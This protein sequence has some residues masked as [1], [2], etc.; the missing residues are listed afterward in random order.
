MAAPNTQRDERT[1]A[2][3]VG[4]GKCYR[5]EKGTVKKGGIKLSRN[6]RDVPDGVWA[7]RDLDNMDRFLKS[8]GADCVDSFNYEDLVGTDFANGKRDI[9]ER[10]EKHFEK[11]A[12]YFILYYT[13]HGD[14]DGSWVFPVIRK[15]QSPVED[16][17]SITRQGTRGEGHRGSAA[18]VLDQPIQVDVEVHVHI[19]NNSTEQ[20]SWSAE[21]IEESLVHASE[22]KDKLSEV[23]VEDYTEQPAAEGSG[24]GNTVKPKPSH[25]ETDI[26]HISTADSDREKANDR[27]DRTRGYSDF[28]ILTTE[29]KLP[30][31]TRKCD[32]IT[33][34]E[35]LD[36]WKEKKRDRGD[37]Y[38]MI[39]LD[40]CYAGKWVEK[41]DSDEHRDWRDICIQAVCRSIEI[42]KV[43]RDQ[44]SSVFTRDFVAAHRLSIPQKIALSVLDHAFVLNIAS[45][46]TSDTF[47]PVSS[48]YA[49]FGEIKKF[50]SYDDMYL[51][52]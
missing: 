27:T 1:C 19:E 6:K 47:S 16:P 28:E 11:E 18:A 24:E 21:R 25:V 14:H 50:D 39:I 40:C 10:I 42:C 35:I 34:E 29:E 17:D 38:L 26:E 51:T 4:S 3:L 44:Q 9:I 2:L 23:E 33:F 41:I 5:D 37:R 43:T 49:P 12:K 7:Q 13:G 48:Q 32:F 45:M 15:V 31:A 20:D 8:K 30:K 52:F 36:I 22:Q 46:L